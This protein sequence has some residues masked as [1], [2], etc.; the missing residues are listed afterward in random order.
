MDYYNHSSRLLVGE[1]SHSRNHLRDRF[2]FFFFRPSLSEFKMMY[3]PT[4]WLTG[5]KLVRYSVSTVPAVAFFF[6][7]H[8]K[9]QDWFNR[10]THTNV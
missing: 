3:R 9:I 2:L 8:S 6:L 10:A 7:I 1:K 5:G 4:I